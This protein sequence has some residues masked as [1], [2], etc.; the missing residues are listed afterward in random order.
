MPVQNIYSGFYGKLSL[1][2]LLNAAINYT[3]TCDTLLTHF[4]M[5]IYFVDSPKHSSGFA[6]AFQLYDKKIS[7]LSLEQKHTRIPFIGT[8]T[9]NHDEWIHVSE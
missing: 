6:L 2:L 3:H 7:F 8:I 5:C 1:F 4:Q 9:I